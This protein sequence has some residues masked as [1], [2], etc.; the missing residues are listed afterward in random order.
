[1]TGLI[2]TLAT[3]EERNTLVNL[4][5]KKKLSK[6][7]REENKVEEN[8]RSIQELEDHDER[9]TVLQR[10]FQKRR[11]KQHERHIHRNNG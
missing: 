7:K 4:K 11:R 3:A 5:I 10:E 8:T 2:S 6:P 9:P 1:M